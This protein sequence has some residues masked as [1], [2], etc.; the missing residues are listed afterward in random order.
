MERP[1]LKSNREL[2]YMREAGQVVAAIHVALLDATQEGTTTSDLDAVVADVVAAHGAKPNFLHYQGFPAT[3][4]ISVNEEVVH[5]IPGSRALQV[6]DIVSYDCGAYVLRDGRRWHA[7]A[8]VTTVVGDAPISDT[9]FVA[10]HLP[11]GIL[12]GVD[13]DVVR[14][15]R[16]LSNLTRG[17]MWAGVAA[18]ATARRVR[19]VSAAVEDFVD[20]ASAQTQRDLGGIPEIIEGYTGHGIGNNLHEE[21]S[22]Y[23]Y[24]TRGRSP[25]IVAGMVL[26]IEPM[27]IAGNSASAVLEDDWTV[28][29]VEGTDAAHWE[30]TVAIGKSGISVLTSPDAG[31]V[32]LAPY[33]ITPVLD[34]TA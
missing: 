25:K 18:T 20:D 34:F 5:G 30:H 24:R 11:D 15:R 28:V 2:E 27:V 1:T 26:C 16:A 3:V 19:D 31:T 14:R 33:G 7:D 23:N 9:Q 8:A 22:V 17:S 13:E 32:A 21:P 29:T 4:C 10:G 12:T 6:G